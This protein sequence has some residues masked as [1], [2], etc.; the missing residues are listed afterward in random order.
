M[1]PAFT[2]ELQ[3]SVSDCGLCD[4]VE[5]VAHKIPIH[6]FI[7]ASF[8][9]CTGCMSVNTVSLFFVVVCVYMCCIV[10]RFL[11]CVHDVLFMDV[12]PFWLPIFMQGA[13]PP[14]WLA[15]QFI[16]SVGALLLWW[17]AYTA[18]AKLQA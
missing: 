9:V 2:V 1:K 12:L 7:M 17:L 8:T 10:C 4:D 16:A 18:K 15:T 11:V 13:S 5:R 6:L 3:H 14:F